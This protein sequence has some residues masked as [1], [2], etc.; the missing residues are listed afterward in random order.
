[1]AYTNYRR[2]FGRD[3][4][5]DWPP[6]RLTARGASRGSASAPWRRSTASGGCRGV[7]PC[8]SGSIRGWPITHE[9]GHLPQGNR[10]EIQDLPEPLLE[11]ERGPEL[12][13]GQTQPRVLGAARR[14]FGHR[15]WHHFRHRGPQRG[16]EE[17]AS[18]HNLRRSAADGWRGRGARPAVGDLRDRD[19]VLPAVYGT[20]ECHVERP[21]PG[22]RVRRDAGTLRRHRGLR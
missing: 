10:Q 12:R 6:T 8:S 20:R 2:C 13:Q 16:G 14:E 1:M 11:V 19:G 15:A 4:G 3:E 17:Y 5:G 9:A 7:R 18:E 21:D 22:H